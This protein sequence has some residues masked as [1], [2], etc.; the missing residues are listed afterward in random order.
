MSVYYRIKGKPK[1]NK[2]QYNVL[3]LTRLK[4]KNYLRR[5]VGS[6]AAHR[7][8]CDWAHTGLPY[9]TRRAHTST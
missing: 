4:I 2:S 3:K 7:Q 9:V 6:R 1:G 8:V 5:N